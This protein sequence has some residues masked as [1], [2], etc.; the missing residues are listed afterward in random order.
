[1]FAE[2][3]TLATHASRICMLLER[4]VAGSTIARPSAEVVEPK[5]QDGK[6]LEKTLHMP[7]SK[8]DFLCVFDIF[9]CFAHVFNYDVAVS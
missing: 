6:K 8:N 4:A 3:G 2:N 1:M 5:E 7:R 9:L